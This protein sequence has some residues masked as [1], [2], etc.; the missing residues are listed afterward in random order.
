MEP[1][2]PVLQTSVPRRWVWRSTEASIAEKQISVSALIEIPMAICLYS[3]LAYYSPWPWFSLLACLA[4]PLL[5]L[6]SDQSVRMG[7]EMLRHYHNLN[8]QTISKKHLWIVVVASILFSGLFDYWVLSTPA[9]QWLVEHTGWALGWRSALVGAVEVVV[10]AVGAAVGAGAVVGAI[11]G[12]IVGVGMG[13]G[14]VAGAGAVLSVG[15]GVVAG[16]GAGAVVVAVVVVGVGVVV[17]VVAVL[18]MVVVAIA[19]A[20]VGVDVG[21]IV[22]VGVDAVAV[23]VAV[24]VVVLAVAVAVSVAVATGAIAGAG[25]FFLPG[26]IFGIFL[27]SLVIRSWATLRH[28]GPGFDDF[29]GNFFETVCVVDVWHPPS[30]LPGAEEVNKRL[31]IRYWLSASPDTLF[32]SWVRWMFVGVVY[33]PALLYR[34]NLKASSWLWGP[35]AWALSRASWPNKEDMRVDM[36]SFTHPVL[37]FLILS[38]TSGF[39]VWLLSHWVPALTGEPIALVKFLTQVFTQILSVP[40]WNLRTVLSILTGLVLLLLW[41]HVFRLRSAYQGD[42]VN[43]ESFEKLV[44]EKKDEKFGKLANSVRISRRWTLVLIFFTFSTYALVFALNHW[45]DPVQ[46]WVWDWLRPWV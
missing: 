5:L 46:R 14:V 20:G 26:L 2:N 35:V 10:V 23:A 21:A 36:A 7:V 12:A 37:L 24:V 45:P 25:A 44:N 29:V 11:V 31:G 19:G 17:G 13:A 28:L 16:A 30:L 9:N 43:R 18:A 33:L 38:V 4:A 42:L 15:P 40:G 34:W 1:P 6:R 3:A 8:Q 32:E 27:R 22:G 39:V 41:W